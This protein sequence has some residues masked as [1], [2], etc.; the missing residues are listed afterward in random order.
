MRLAEHS[1]MRRVRCGSA[2]DVANQ[3]R[4]QDAG[5]RDSVRALA[6]AEEAAVFLGELIVD[7][8]IEVVFV[9]D[10]QRVVKEIE[11]GRLTGDIRLRIFLI[12]S[13]NVDAGLVQAWSGRRNDGIC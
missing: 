8:H 10:Q 11:G 7:L 9:S 2:D 4:R 1:L 13:Q 6:I 3:R 12:E 5:L